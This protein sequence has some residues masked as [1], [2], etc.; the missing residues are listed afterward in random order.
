MGKKSKI[1]IS[2][3]EAG[4]TCDKNQYKEASFW[5]KVLLNIH[6]IYCRACREYTKDN[7]KLTKLLNKKD[8]EFLEQE[9]KATL[10]TSFQKELAKYQ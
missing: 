2:C 10:E 6:L 8:V 3:D 4:H 7:G 5:S 9:E 1:F